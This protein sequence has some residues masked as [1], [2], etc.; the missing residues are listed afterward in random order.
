MD[1]LSLFYVIY[2]NFLICIGKVLDS[3]FIL[4]LLKS[5]VLCLRFI[6]MV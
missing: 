4:S 6:L 5:V 2:F 3:Y 1:F